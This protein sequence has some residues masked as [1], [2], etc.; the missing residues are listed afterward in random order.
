M[1]LQHFQSLY[2]PFSRN[3]EIEKI[4][5]Y[6]KGGNSCQILALPGVGRSTILG[7][8][9]YNKNV[10]V[11]HLGEDLQKWYHFVLCD[12]SE[13]RKRSLFDVQKFIFL[14]L[15]DSL[16]ERG[17][18]EEYE[19]ANR[20]FKESVELNDEL[21]IFQGLKR[22]IDLL[23][24][25]KEL[26]I[27]L[28]FD[29][30]EEYIPMLTPE[31]FSN[32]RV[33]RNRAKYRFSVV[34]SLHRPLEDV[35]EPIQLADF[36]EFSADHLI[37]L[38]L[39]DKPGLEFRISYL[40]KVTEKK[41]E[42]K[43]VDEVIRLTGGHGKLARLCLEAVL[44]SEKEEGKRDKDLQHFLLSQKQVQK[45]LL[46]IWQSLTPAEQEM[47]G[48]G[49]KSEEER[50][51]LEKLGLIDNDN[52]TIPLFAEFVK[53]QAQKEE[54]TPL[55][56]RITYDV[57]TNEITKGVN[58]IS[59]TLTSSEFKLLRF[60]IENADKVLERDEVI[61]SVW[62]DMATT[63]GVTDQALDQLIFRVRRKIEDDPNN[64]SHLQT[65]K[66]RGFKFTS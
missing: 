9:S 61:S 22:T 42:K 3:S 62:K 56:D 64:P 43:V 55:S 37:Y 40:E 12:F 46:E 24:I 47:L 10:R 66:G 58:T 36:Y 1:D 52:I 39:Y 57:N 63:A 25:E 7:L 65:V 20:I 18:K 26:T 53:Q 48:E 51:N 31:F 45:A 38:S 34:F 11:L 32:L 49:G 44:A 21:V 27:V 19:K 23:A 17:M 16:R 2:P 33:L 50:R 14:N 60:C 5:G 13:V 8:L 41:L 54:A 35:L 15:V 30:F 28:L 6:I 29:R 4:L 59:D